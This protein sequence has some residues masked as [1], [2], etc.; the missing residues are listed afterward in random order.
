MIIKSAKKSLLLLLLPVIIYLPTLPQ[1][2]GLPIS[3][4]GAPMPSLAPMLERSMPAVV[5]ISTS[6]QI[7][8]KENP[9]LQDPFFRQFFQIPNQSRQQQK[10]SLGS[11]VIIDSD[12]GL[13]LTVLIRLSQTSTRCS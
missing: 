11:G 9:L 2:A 8:V 1:A 12:R 4:E 13:V 5:N 6:T 10:N 3:A 7:E